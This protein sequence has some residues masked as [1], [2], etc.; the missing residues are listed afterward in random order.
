MTMRDTPCRPSGPDPRKIT[1]T[2][3]TSKDEN[4]SLLLDIEQKTAEGKKSVSSCFYSAN[5]ES[6]ERSCAPKPQA[7]S[8]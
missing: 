3:A 7:W 5:A 4:A 6:S 1:S 8:S 2:N